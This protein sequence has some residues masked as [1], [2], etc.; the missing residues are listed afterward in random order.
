[1]TKQIRLFQPLVLAVFSFGFFGGL[2]L[3]DSGCHAQDEEHDPLAGVK[4][5][6]A[7]DN[8]AKIEHVAK[9]LDGE[10]YFCCDECKSAFESNPGDYL[11]KA[12]HQLVI[13]GQYA[14]KAC[15]I[16]GLEVNE[17]KMVSVG[18]TELGVCCGR[19]EGSI[20][21]A[22]D[23]AHKA[24][25]V[26]NKDAFAKGFEKAIMLDGV[27][28][29]VGGGDAS[30]EFAMDYLGGTI[31]FCCET[32]ADTFSE[33]ADQYSNLANYQLVATGQF[34]QKNCPFSG[35]QMKTEHSTTVGLIE[36]GFCNPGCCAKV[37][38]TE[39]I[40][41]QIDMVFTKEAFT[42]AFVSR[43]DVKEDN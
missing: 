4:C 32:C 22:P 18:G 27:T 16:T 21:G 28:C 39:E 41:D 37:A 30:K 36:V 14:Q 3:F 40:K 42:K 15:P 19:C 24:N 35:A 8:G 12:N 6:V 5:I 9:H 20:N 34:V 29:P 23:L 2:G 10:V 38:D 11:V 17:D 33:D 1:M 7:G 31:F 13:T 25:L 26:F 43:K